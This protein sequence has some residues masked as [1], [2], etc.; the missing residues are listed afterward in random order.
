MSKIRFFGDEIPSNSIR[1]AIGAPGD[2]ATSF[3]RFLFGKTISCGCIFSSG[4]CVWSRSCGR[5]GQIESG[6]RADSKTNVSRRTGESIQPL[7]SWY[8]ILVQIGP[9]AQN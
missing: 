9:G 8:S 1:L 6:H 5:V 2:A 7:Q 3:A 4:M